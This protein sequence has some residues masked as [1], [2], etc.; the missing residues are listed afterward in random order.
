MTSLLKEEVIRLAYILAF[1][2]IPAWLLHAGVPMLFFGLLVYV[3]LHLRN[4]HKLHHWLKTNHKDTP[5]ELSG[6]WED[7]A[8]NIYRLQQ[9]EQAA[10]HNLLAI[11]ARARTSMSAL[12]EAVVL[13]DHRPGRRDGLDELD[14]GG[15]AA[16]G[17]LPSA[18]HVDRQGRVFRRTRNE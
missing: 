6:I 13:T 7:I 12:E 17:E 1:F 2:A 14:H 15:G 16:V 18:D 4:L 3:I 5:P 9:N 10:K 11:I 8:E